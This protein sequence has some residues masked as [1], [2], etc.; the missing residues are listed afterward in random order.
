M[1]LRLTALAVLLS[2]V[3][4]VFS[5][6]LEAAD[7]KDLAIRVTTMVDGFRKGD[8]ETVI[9]MTHPSIYGLAGDKEAFEAMVR[10]AMKSI[11]ET[12]LEVQEARVGE[13]SRT[14]Q[15]GKETI[16]FVPVSLVFS[17]KDKKIRGIS[18]YVAVKGGASNEWLFLDGS[19]FK[20]QP[21]A[22]KQI[23]PGLPADVVLPEIRQEPVEK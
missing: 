12:G 20:G 15:A 23:L 10:D 7:K 16:C 5:G 21:E 13:P 6:E 11:K 1:K 3:I 19:G 4:P 14:W 2:S 17:L 18:Y 9:R 8:A 22:L